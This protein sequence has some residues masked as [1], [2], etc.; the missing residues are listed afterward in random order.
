[1]AALWG[2][3]RA[4]EPVAPDPEGELAE[5]SKRAAAPTGADKGLT[6][7]AIAG[8]W[9]VV[10]SSREDST[11]IGAIA[12]IYPETIAWS[13]RPGAAMALEPVCRE[14]V[15]EDLGAERSAE[16]TRDL[17]ARLLKGGREVAKSRPHEIRC[18]S[19]DQ[20]GPPSGTDLVLSESGKLLVGWENGEVLALVKL[21][22]PAAKDP[23]EPGDYK[24][25]TAR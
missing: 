7:D 14:P 4:P 23:M 20:W 11:L 5:S 1:M 2:C 22:R 17:A 10:S 25:D 18:A 13:Y 24:A 12:E 19:G 3:E 15:L 8:G 16:A 21:E 9:R 6:L